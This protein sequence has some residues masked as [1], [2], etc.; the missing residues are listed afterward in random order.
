MRILV[1]F[2][3]SFFSGIASAKNIINIGT[4]LSNYATDYNF[5]YNL[6]I[7]KQFYDFLIFS[8]YF[9]QTL[10]DQKINTSL[11]TGIQTS[12][13]LSTNTFHITPK[14]SYFLMNEVRNNQIFSSYGNHLGAD[15][16]FYNRRRT[17]ELKMSYDE[18]YT[19]IYI[20]KR[21]GVGIIL[22]F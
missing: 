9:N 18:D 15:L 21:I 22:S 10:P 6:E 7:G 19:E 13:K 11:H 1:I 12:I 4:F 3:I 16:S 2:L 20:R 14:I 8:G 5:G 17:L